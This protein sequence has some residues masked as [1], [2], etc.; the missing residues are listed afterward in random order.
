MKMGPKVR[1]AA[2]AALVLALL[3]L[4]LGFLPPSSA[5]AS[6]SSLAL[7][8]GWNLVA[9]GPETVFPS[10]LFGW[11]GSSYVSTTT[12][13]AWQGYWCRVSDQEWVSLAAVYGPHDTTLVAGWNLIGNPMSYPATLALP[14]GRVAFLYDASA[15]T[16]V[17]TLILAPGQGAWVRGEEGERV[18]LL[19]PAPTISALSVTSGPTSGG[20]AVVVSGAAFME[21]TEVS[22]GGAILP[23]S[24]YAVDSDTQITIPSVPGHTAGTVGVSV[25]TV[26]GT[27][28]DTLADDYTYVDVTA[29][30][31]VNDFANY[32]VFQRDIGATSRSVTVSGTYSNMNWNRVEARVLQHGTGTTAVGWTT[33][34]STPG[35]ET[36]AGD[37]AVPQGGWYNVE[38]RALDG[39]GSVLGSDRGTNKWGVGMIILVI[40]QSNMSGRGQTPYAVATSDLAVNYSNAGRWEHLADPYDDE[41]PAGAVDDDNAKAAGS[42]IPG[43]ANSLLQTFD[44]PIA[45]VPAS[46]GGSNL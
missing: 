38:V 19:P 10:P 17:S 36:F 8:P 21:V 29:T 26:S 6:S 41:S 27:S 13:L 5:L 18:A 45:F 11:D 23:A 25:T 3:L 7:Q 32:R 20:T 39:A 44:F 42:M 34:D 1:V 33:I 40:G 30:V 24:G 4:L 22:F 12:P 43:I 37:L 28:A 35:G 14:L 2:P 16:Y 31:A 9:A 15:Q 46:K